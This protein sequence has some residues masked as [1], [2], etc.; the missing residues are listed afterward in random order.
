MAKW[1]ERKEKIKVFV[2][3]LGTF[4]S[5]FVGEKTEMRISFRGETFFRLFCL[6]WDFLIFLGEH[7]EFCSKRST[8]AVVFT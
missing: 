2:S 7:L 1:I 4:L 6:L 3:L 5:T 8:K